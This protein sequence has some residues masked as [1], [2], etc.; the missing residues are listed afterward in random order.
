M[1]KTLITLLFGVST[2]SLQAQSYTSAVGL[3]LG[4]Y[5][6]ITYKHFLS[7][8]VAFEGLVMS[9]YHGLN[10]TALVEFN[11][12]LGNTEGLN[13]YYGFGGHLGYYNSYYYSYYSGSDYNMSLGVDGILGIEYTFSELPIN[14]SL[15]WKPTYNLFGGYY[16]LGDSGALSIRY[17]LE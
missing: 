1:K 17:V 5:R 16:F 8:K 6:G 3:R 15:D 7:E 11:N 13:W 4:F 10:L 12:D 9:R 14:I 2:L